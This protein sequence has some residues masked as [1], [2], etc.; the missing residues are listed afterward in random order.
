MYR[1]LFKHCLK[2]GLAE[3]LSGEES[4][5]QCSRRGF[6]PWIKKTTVEG[7]GNSNILIWEIPWWATVQEVAEESDM[8]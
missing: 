1:I 5:C 3:W 8:T 6:N 7:N 4:A 2:T